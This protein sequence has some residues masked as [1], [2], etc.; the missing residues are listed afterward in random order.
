M[1]MKDASYGEAMKT[2]YPEQIG[3]AVSVGPEGKPNV[4]VLGWLMPASGVPPMIAISVGHTRYSHECITKAKE[5]VVVFPAVGQ[6][7]P[8]TLCGT[9]SGRDVDKFKEAG[10]KALEAKKVKPPL[11][12]G[13]VAN[14]ECRLVAECEAG[15]HTIFVGEVLAAHVNADASVERLYNFSGDFLGARPAR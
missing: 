5:F 11:V 14:F 3:W 9:K 4:I 12:D 2:K 7:D 15:D 13:A 1:A 6:E 10:L 8:T